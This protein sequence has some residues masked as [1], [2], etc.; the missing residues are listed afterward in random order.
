MIEKL[1]LLDVV[2][3][4]EKTD[5]LPKGALGTIVEILDNEVFEVEFSNI[6]GESYAFKALPAHNLLKVFYEPELVY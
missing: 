5:T 2:V 4:T 1:Q 6:K 3:L